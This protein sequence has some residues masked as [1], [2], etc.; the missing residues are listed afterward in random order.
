LKVYK[1]EAVHAG[2][3]LML[4]GSI[5]DDHYKRLIASGWTVTVKGK[6]SI[7]VDD[8]G[9]DEPLPVLEHHV[10]PLPPTIN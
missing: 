2:E 9:K 6:Y 1:V 5:Y 8:A 3:K 10:I 4:A 7:K